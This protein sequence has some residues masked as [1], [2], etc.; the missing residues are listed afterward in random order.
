MPVSNHMQIHSPFRQDS[1]KR[2][3]CVMLKAV[4]WLF[5]LLLVVSQGCST[6]FQAPYRFVGP[7]TEEYH[8]HRTD[9]NPPEERCQGQADGSGNPSIT[10]SS[11]SNHPYSSCDKVTEF[12]PSS[13]GAATMSSLPEP[14][15]LG[16]STPLRI[17]AVGRALEGKIELFLILVIPTIFQNP[18]LRMPLMI[19]APHI[20]DAILDLV[21][22]FLAEPTPQTLEENSG[23]ACLGPVISQDRRIA[24]VTVTDL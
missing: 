7:T 18:F 14:A 11:E 6:N 17:S 24:P 4:F 5:P 10:D 2:R 22:W 15:T 3:P 1:V 19:A 9:T 8:D 13:G 12:P 23:M 20:E 16:N 21:D